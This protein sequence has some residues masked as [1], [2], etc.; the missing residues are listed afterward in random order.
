[1]QRIRDC[2]KL[3]LKWDRIIT[4]LP[5]RLR[6]SRKKEQ[7]IAGAK[8]CKSKKQ[9][10]IS[11]EQILSDTVYKFGTQE[12]TDNNSIHRTCTDSNWTKHIMEKG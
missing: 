5:P 4:L 7:K 10:V 6:S 11:S 12:L 2:S 9:W 3:Y 1:M 8:D